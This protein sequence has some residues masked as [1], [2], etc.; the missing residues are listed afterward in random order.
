MLRQLIL[1]LLSHFNCK[2]IDARINYFS[3]II[4][5]KIITLSKMNCRNWRNWRPSK[6]YIIHPNVVLKGS[7]DFTFKRKNL[8]LASALNRRSVKDEAIKC[9]W[10]IRASWIVQMNPA[11]N[12]ITPAANNIVVVESSFNFLCMH[13]VLLTMENNIKLPQQTCRA[14]DDK[15][16]PGFSNIQFHRI[17][18]YMYSCNLSL[19]PVKNIFLNLRRHQKKCFHVKCSQTHKNY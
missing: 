15:Y 14:I 19:T 1:F 4:S 6:L 3:Q 8:E 13:P 2:S 18:K 9:F 17:W 7:N 11:P 16:I 10:V 5:V 12:I